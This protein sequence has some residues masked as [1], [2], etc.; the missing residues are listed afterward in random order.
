MAPCIPEDPPGVCL[1]LLRQRHQLLRADALTEPL[2][3]HGLPPVRTIGATA[4]WTLP[5]APG[6][7]PGRFAIDASAA[8]LYK[9]TLEVGERV[10][11]SSGAALVKMPGAEFRRFS[12]GTAVTR[13]VLTVSALVTLLVLCDL[14]P[15]H[16]GRQSSFAIIPDT[17][18]VTAADELV[19]I[20]LMQDWIWARRKDCDDGVPRDDSTARGCINWIGVTSKGDVNEHHYEDYTNWINFYRQFGA[21]GPD[22]LGPIPFLVVDGNHD[23][24]DAPNYPDCLA[25]PE[26]CACGNPSL[27]GKYC[28]ESYYKTA[29]PISQYSYPGSGLLEC[30][31]PVDSYYNL[32]GGED[33]NCAFQWSSGHGFDLLVFG[34]TWFGTNVAFPNH[35]GPPMLALHPD[36]PTFGFAHRHIGIDTNAVYDPEDCSRHVGEDWNHLMKDVPNWVAFFN[37]HDQATISTGEIVYGRPA[38]AIVEHNSPHPGYPEGT[39]VVQF[40]LN[41]QDYHF[42]GPNNGIETA[43]IEVMTV[44]WDENWM[45]VQIYEPLYDRY[46]PEG[47]SM[48]AGYTWTDLD[49][50]RFLALVDTDG[51]GVTDVNDNC[52]DLINP[53][54]DDA[55]DDGVGDLCDNCAQAY[56]PTQGPAPL[57]QTLLALDKDHF[58]WDHPADV[59]YIRGNLAN[60]SAYSFHFSE[61]LV[62]ASEFTDDSSVSPG[63]AYF[64][65]VR[66][67]CDVGSWQTGLGA[68]PQRDEVLP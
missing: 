65:M 13:R 33:L 27:P 25:D 14:V 29:F 40:F 57:G 48:F 39:P 11:R 44:D 38:C 41:W 1:L 23:E 21:L 19:V 32:Y 15:L 42:P 24:A 63:T 58:G 64:Y 49:L 18:H 47:E 10:P 26:T 50:D 61:T 3:I 43:I 35:W 54:Q 46:V 17:Q 30:N 52:M 36:L 31:L 55:D 22:G 67:D 12:L 56:N 66:P 6:H 53:D 60:A 9:V 68:Q 2:W 7:A 45:Q 37:G 62:S 16:A 34:F 20:P 59:V 5:G 8:C 51:D 4:I 28:D